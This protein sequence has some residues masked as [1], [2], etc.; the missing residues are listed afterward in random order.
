M[1]GLTID[2]SNYTD[3]LTLDAQVWNQTTDSPTINDIFTPDREAS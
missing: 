3:V 2:Y 1:V